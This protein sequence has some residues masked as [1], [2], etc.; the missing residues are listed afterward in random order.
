MRLD[1]MHPLQHDTMQPHRCC[2][3]LSSPMQQAHTHCGGPASSRS[4][5]CLSAQTPADL[6]SN[7]KVPAAAASLLCVC[8]C[9]AGAHT[10]SRPRCLPMHNSTPGP[11]T[12]RSWLSWT[13]VC[14]RPAR[15]NSRF[16]E[17]GPEYAPSSRFVGRPSA[18]S[19]LCTLICL[20][21]GCHSL[22]ALLGPPPGR[23][24][25]G[26]WGTRAGLVCVPAPSG[27]RACTLQCTLEAE[28][29]T[30]GDADGGALQRYQSGRLAANVMLLLHCV[31]LH[32][33]LLH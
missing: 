33:V 10:W 13:G 21:L 4:V 11:A 18:L 23:G 29:H 32:R 28:A 9:R 1:T 27:A 12:R 30:D 25:L 3:P 7:S 19:I 6:A 20:W 24:W 26:L 14:A 15:L 31:L 2:Q 22:P 8:S 5:C 16:P 17:S